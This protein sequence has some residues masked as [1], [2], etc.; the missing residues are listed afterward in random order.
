MTARSKLVSLAFFALAATSFLGMQC[1]GSKDPGYCADCPA[2][3]GSVDGGPDASVACGGTCGGATPYCNEATNTCVGCLQTS[4]CSDA[5]KS[6]CDT[7]SNTCV[8]CND[9][10]QCSHIPGKGICNVGT[11]V[12]CT[13]ATETAVCGNFYCDPVGKTCTTT[14]RGTLDS[15]KACN[16]EAECAVGYRCV[17]MNFQGNV[18]PGGYCLLVSNGSNCTKPYAITITRG[19]ISDPNTA[20]PPSYCGINESKTTCE[21]VLDRVADTSCLVSGN[22][23]DSACGAPSTNDGKC[24][25]VGTVMNLCTYECVTATECQSGELC[26]KVAGTVDGSPK[27]C[28]VTGI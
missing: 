22:A 26:N 17:P 11:C 28:G 15:C 5:T 8:A 7:A 1:G 3:D 24:T 6:V 21:A 23:D 27:Y 20:S 10:A 16:A 2:A 19:S 18:R 12:Q 13:E 9:N 25:K 4:Q 14:P